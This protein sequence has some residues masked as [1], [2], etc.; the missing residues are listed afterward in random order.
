MPTLLNYCISVAEMFFGQGSSKYFCFIFD[1]K[2]TK[3]LH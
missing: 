3:H 1:K 2:I